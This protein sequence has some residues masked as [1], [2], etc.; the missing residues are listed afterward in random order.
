MS[1]S[2]DKRRLVERKG[3]SQVTQNKKIIPQAKPTNKAKV[4]KLKIQSKS[5]KS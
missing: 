5:K 2:K 3:H 1:V 4:A